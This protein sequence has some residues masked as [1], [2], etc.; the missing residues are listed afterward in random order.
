MRKFWILLILLLPIWLYSQTISYISL[1]KNSFKLG[2]R[3]NLA[4]KTSS[5]F[6]SNNVFTV[7][8]SD[9]FGSFASFTEIG[10]INARIDTTIQ[11][12]IPDT[13]PVGNQYKIRV[14]AS[15]PAYTSNSHPDAIIIFFGR[16]FYVATNGDDSNPGT[17]DFPFKTIQKAIDTA[18]YYDTI[19]VKP[20]T[21]QENIVFRGFDLALISINGAE[22]TIIDGQK[23]GNPVVTLENGEGPGTIIQ[24][25]TIQ[26]G[27]NYQM[28]NGPGITIKYQNTS[29]VLKNLIIK[30]NEAWAFGG[31]IFCYNAG[32]VKIVNCTIE[33]NKAKYFGA[34]IYTDQTILDIDGCIIRKNSSGGVYNWRSY[35]NIRNSLIY[36]NNSNEVTFFSDL[37][38]Q[39]KPKI[40]NST[41]ISRNKY[42]GLLISGRFIGEILNSI[43][44][45]QDS[46]IAI[47]GNR[48]DTLKIDYSIVYNYPKTFYHDNVVLKSGNTFYSDD[49][50]FVAPA[51]ENFT[52]DSCSPALGNALKSVAP[53]TDVYGNKRPVDLQEED[54]PDIGAIE[55]LQSQR[56]N[57]VS[58]TRVSKTKFCKGGSFTLD[59]TTGGCPFYLDNE[60]I[61][62]LSNS[63]GE[64]NPSYEL[65]R[66]KSVN[67]GSINCTIPRGIPSGSNYKVRIRATNVLYRSKPYPENIAIF[68]NPN[69]KIL[70]QSLVCSSREYEYWTDSSEFPTN[71]WIIKNGYS[72]NN[73]TENRI[74]V[75]WYDST[76]GKI[77]LIQT[78]IA[79]CVDSTELNV[80]ILPTP[81]KPSIQQT[82]DGQL[83]SSYPSWNQWYLN[84]MPIQGATGRIYK[85]TKNGYYSV[86][87]V[88]PTGC[89]SE[90]SDSIYVVVSSVDKESEDEFV[91]YIFD[92][93]IK[94]K[95]L[96]NNI[97][98]FSIFDLLGNEI[99]TD[100]INVE[101]GEA[102]IILNEFR[103]GVYFV[104]F[105]SADFVRVFKLVLLK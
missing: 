49:P 97:K 6:A 54:N 15:N 59:Y 30:D 31:G 66:V 35:S 55:S 24:G 102:T 52:P 17:N 4:L 80:T 94:I 22:Q 36:W 63:K 70:G 100:R 81:S 96:K 28:D 62:E 1:P 45:C 40:V 76:N 75:I 89:E 72:Y 32:K 8:L 39:M 2:E 85:P 99:W 43:F 64:F 98:N 103:E 25:F 91:L 79:G 50:L 3:F 29:P 46:S 95:G 58:I 42:Y 73:L 67:S 13:I 93:S 86:K 5:A 92:N 44:Y 104:V 26:N 9:R 33:N 27:V 11:C 69:V 19:L 74:K 48:Y 51:S 77:K 53:P 68:D 101:N 78:N 12:Q 10:K 65:G 34:G 105:R 41:I 38:V 61:A 16:K 37:G 14:A 83:V 57:I 90:M 87:I 71:R 47:E 56:S 60:F 88:P 82:S 23:N 21:Y 18:W 7:Q 84:G 20:G